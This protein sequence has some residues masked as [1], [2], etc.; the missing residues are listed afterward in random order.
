MAAGP[1]AL[2]SDEAVDAAATSS[3]GEPVLSVGTVLGEVRDAIAAAFPPRRR[4]WIRGE[5]QKITESQRGHCYID[6]IDPDT[7]SG[8]APTLKVNCWRST[9]VP[10]RKLLDVQGVRLQA[11]TVVTLGGRVE[12]YAPR[13]QVNFVA[14]ELDVDA[15]LGRLAA[16]RAALVR[17]LGAEGLL[18]RGKTI[19]VPAVPLR[20]GLVASPKTEGCQ[21]F[22]G[23][24]YESGFAFEVLLAPVTVQGAAAPP[25]IV[26]ALST[27]Q[28][29]GCDL[30]VVVRGGGARADLAAFD[31]EVVARAIATSSVAVWTGI[32]HTGDQ[33][34]ADLVAHTAWRTPTACGQA[35]V[36]LVGRWWSTVE[37][38]AAT[39]SR[40]AARRAQGEEQ[41][42]GERRR[43]LVAGVV[44]QLRSHR[45]SL[46]SRASRLG[47]GAS[48]GTALA[49]LQL[50]RTSARLVPGATAAIQREG[51]RVAS[52]RRLLVAYDVERQLERGYTLTFD[53]AGALVRQAA[54]AV[55]A[56]TVVTRFV[57]G[58]VRSTVVDELVA[59]RIRQEGAS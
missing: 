40:L 25:S 13:A 36:E 6:L 37:G 54:G 19:P 22:L 41:L 14:E 17:Q 48:R 33:S 51:E 35:V 3:S 46:N 27:V 49:L 9:W 20:I 45:M 16:Q 21:D 24:L 7:G 43:R 39:I 55:K 26:E 2:A 29:A 8:D 1:G 42:A 10:L 57:D 4:V 32:G 23:Q 53:P 28:G 11:G 18:D 59:G 30:V 58:S 12:F 47:T 50:A 52:W 56:G 38:R 34:V 15:L 44:G 5:I 31:T